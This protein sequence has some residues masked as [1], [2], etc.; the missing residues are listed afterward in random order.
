MLEVPRV[1]RI[2]G[3]PRL[4]WT[5]ALDARLMDL[6]ADGYSFTQ[7]G[8]MMGIAPSSVGGR[9]KRLRMAMGEQAL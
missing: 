2:G 9:F 8:R 5:D 4:E 7:I 1:T 6:M 3:A